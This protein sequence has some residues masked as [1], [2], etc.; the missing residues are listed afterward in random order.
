[1]VSEIQ[2]GAP[3]SQLQ[4]IWIPT[5]ISLGVTLLRLTGE[6]RHWSQ[7]WFSSETGG[8]DPQG[9]S[10]I[11]GITWLAA[12]FGI[13]FAVK[14]T[15][16]GHLPRSPAGVVTSSVLGLA[17]IFCSRFLFSA[18]PGH[19]P[20]ILIPLW[21]CWAAAASAQYFAWPA[22]FKLLLV[23]G[24][25]S[26]IPVAIVMFLAMTGN[27]GTHYDYVGMP[28]AFQMPLIPRYLWLAFFP[29]LV[30]WVSYTIV[31][32]TLAASMAFFVVRRRA[33]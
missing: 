15:R 25:A 10:W 23:Y 24:F 22:L 17:T 9:I 21:F 20:E 6:L 14:L 29:Q 19:F 27:W 33:A 1:M 11:I 3:Q 30:A 28:P 5:L 8:T 7:R 2:R 16:A 18:F 32:G 12:P 13:Y 4:L 31:L 26:R